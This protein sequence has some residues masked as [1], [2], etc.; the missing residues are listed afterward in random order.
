MTACAIQ[1][2]TFLLRS[3][4]RGS[5]II[6]VAEATADIESPVV[7][8]QTSI[9]G[10]VNATPTVRCRRSFSRA[11]RATTAAMNAAPDIVPTIIIEETASVN[12]RAVVYRSSQACPLAA[13]YRYRVAAANRINFDRPELWRGK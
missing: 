11:D 9:F 1:T 10:M 6:A 12:W 2:D 8:A 13:D 7:T 4:L 5:T 3:R